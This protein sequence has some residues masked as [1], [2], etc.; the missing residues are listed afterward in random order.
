MEGLARTFLAAALFAAACGPATLAQ[1]PGAPVPIPVP[2]IPAPPQLGPAPRLALPKLTPPGKPALG[3]PDAADLSPI[4]IPPEAAITP[5][6]K[7]DPVPA[8]LSGALTAAPPMVS[9]GAAASQIEE[10]AFIV[11]P[12]SSQISAAAQSKLRDIAAALA[13]DPAAR[14]EVRTFSPSKSHSESAARRLSLAR[15][16][17]VRQFLTGKGVAD[18][19]ID[20]RPLISQANELNADRIELY[21]ER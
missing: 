4:A 7:N 11:D 13:E 18:A 19:R 5:A 12:G 15:F 2:P 20:G 14:L 16:L 9:P 1:V 6:D 21:I 8:P 3:I 17:A 10:S